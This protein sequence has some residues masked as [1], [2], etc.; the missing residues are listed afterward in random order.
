MSHRLPVPRR[1]AVEVARLIKGLRPLTPTGGKSARSRSGNWNR[2]RHRP[3]AA[4]RVAAPS[5]EAAPR[6]ERRTHWR[7]DPRIWARFADVRDPRDVVPRVPRGDCHR[8]AGPL[9]TGFRSRPLDW[10]LVARSMAR[11]FHRPRHGIVPRLR[12]GRKWRDS[13]A[14]AVEGRLVARL[15][16]NRVRALQHVQPM[17]Y[18]PGSPGQDP[19]IQLPQ[20]N[21]GF[22][23]GSD[24]TDSARPVAD[25]VLRRRPPVAH[26]SPLDLGFGWDPY[27]TARVVPTCIQRRAS[28]NRRGPS[29]GS[30]SRSTG[31]A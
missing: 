4:H 29:T 28:E 10:T 18:R 6:K 16:R 17:V 11:G 30:R 27:R 3:R 1:A 25:P 21:R 15:G 5:I 7:D 24:G 23:R 13:A 2:R 9:H 31:S 22:C 8:C 20:R 14:L 26:E 19:R 12:E